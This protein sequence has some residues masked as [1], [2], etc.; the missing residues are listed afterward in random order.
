MM[1][2]MALF[3]HNYEVHIRIGTSHMNLFNTFR[4]TAGGHDSLNAG[5]TINGFCND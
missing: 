4:S 3:V 5:G 2:L 1:P